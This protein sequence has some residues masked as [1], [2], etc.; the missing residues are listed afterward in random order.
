M[1]DTTEHARIGWTTKCEC[2]FLTNIGTHS[3]IG[4]KLARKQLLMRYE[5]TIDQRAR[6]GQIN[7]GAIVSHVRR[8]QQRD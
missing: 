3:E 5:G 1:D 6:W 2:D 8:L 7:I 4:P